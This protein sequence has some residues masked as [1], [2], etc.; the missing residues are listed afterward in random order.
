MCSLHFVDESRI[1][2][3]NDPSERVRASGAAGAR[4]RNSCEGKLELGTHKL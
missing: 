1:V 3:S 2:H 4:K